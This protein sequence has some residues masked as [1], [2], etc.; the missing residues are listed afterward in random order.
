[1]DAVAVLLIASVVTG[2]CRF[3][4]GAVLVTAIVDRVAQLLAALLAIAADLTLFRWEC[5]CDG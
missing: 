1:M 5:G 4:L 2:L 3:V